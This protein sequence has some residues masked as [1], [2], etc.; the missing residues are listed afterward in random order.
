MSN[1]II[2]LKIDGINE[3]I[4]SGFWARL[5]ANLLDG[6]ISVCL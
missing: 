4:Y 1:K 5:G 2:P 6:L 3:N